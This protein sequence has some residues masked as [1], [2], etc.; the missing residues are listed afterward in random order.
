MIDYIESPDRFKTAK[1][2]LPVYATNSGFIKQIDADLVGSLARYLG[3]G[4]MTEK[5]EID[6]TARNYY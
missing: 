5:N 2:V 3:A 1:Y 6:N 4:R